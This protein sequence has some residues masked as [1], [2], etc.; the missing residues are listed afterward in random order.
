M[1]EDWI[2]VHKAPERVGRSKRTVYRWIKDGRVRTIRPL[3]VLWLNLEDLLRVER[4]TA[5]RRAI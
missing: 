4:E 3:R 1:V 2:Q 5:E